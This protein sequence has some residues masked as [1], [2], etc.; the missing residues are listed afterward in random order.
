[1]SSPLPPTIV[2]QPLQGLW[3]GPPL[4]GDVLAEWRGLAT[5][6]PD[7]PV[8]FSGWPGAKFSEPSRPGAIPQHLW[9]E[10][11]DQSA[12]C[13]PAAPD[14]Q[15]WQRGQLTEILLPKCFCVKF[16]AQ[17]KK[18]CDV[19]YHSRLSLLPQPFSSALQAFLSFALC[20]CRLCRFGGQTVSTKTVTPL[21]GRVTE[22]WNGSET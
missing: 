16:T 9:P 6:F 21:S 15:F 8:S 10:P 1:M 13:H 7:L 2:F 18:A 12:P 14:C 17:C 20:F 5:V 19:R 11:P 22:S 3:D 4:G